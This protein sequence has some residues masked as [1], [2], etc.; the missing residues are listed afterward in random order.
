MYIFGE[1]RNL[2]FLSAGPTHFSN[3]HYGQWNPESYLSE[4]GM[5]EFLQHG[6]GC[7]DE[8]SEV[9]EFTVPNLLKLLATSKLHFS[10]Q[11]TTDI[12][13]LN[14]LNVHH[15]CSRLCSLN[16]FDLSLS[17]GRAICW[18]LKCFWYCKI[19]AKGHHTG[20][21]R[22]ISSHQCNAVSLPYAS[23][24]NHHKPVALY[25]DGPFCLSLHDM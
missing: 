17:K 21:I 12:F 1:I 7:A 9:I 22:Y 6:T 24:L 23:A 4:H 14:I 18:L 13:Y 2:T 5:I 15:I 25:Q 10:P 8:C 19:F 3:V 16:M 20:K 11:G